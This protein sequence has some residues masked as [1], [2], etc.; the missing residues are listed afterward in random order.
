VLVSMLVFVGLIIL[1]VAIGFLVFRALPKEAGGPTSW[2]ARI[3]R[4]LGPLRGFV[5][6]GMAGSIVTILLMIPV[7]WLAQAVESSVDRPTF[8]AM[9]AV[10][11]PSSITKFN[12]YATTLGD[13]AT[14]DL[15]CVI[16]VLIL[17][18]AYRRKW[19]IP[20]VSV[21]AVYAAQYWGQLL[22]QKI[23]GRSL[24]PVPGAGGFPS[25]GVSRIIAIDGVLIV[26]VVL[27]V[28][29]VS[30]RWR[31]GLWIGLSAFAV[32]EGFTRVYL[33]LHWVSDAVAGL[34]FGWL[35][36]LTF[37][38]ATGCLA[39]T[40]SSTLPAVP[41]GDPTPQANPS[42]ASINAERIPGSSNA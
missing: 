3:A 11:R 13:R 39:A 35:I 18:F 6:V 23:L 22:L 10:V 25:G 40:R 30:K 20:V 27:L 32:M 8:R 15:V 17:A 37:A 2:G 9:Q 21:A 34:I 14:V 42:V 5:L 29:T 33:S 1:T 4:K 26:L 16:A 12:T 7:G 36:L 24:P 28:A 31:A 19:W 41:G 38:T